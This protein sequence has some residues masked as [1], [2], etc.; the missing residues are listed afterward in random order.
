MK[1]FIE[2]L[3]HN[4]NINYK[5]DLENRIDI[6]YVLERLE[7]I[8]EIKNSDPVDYILGE[9]NELEKIDQYDLLYNLIYNIKE[10]IKKE[11]HQEL[12]KNSKYHNVHLKFLYNEFEKLE[13]I[14]D[15]L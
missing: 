7:D 14:I 11:I 15:I 5:N 13:N 12:E 3:K 4:Q 2:E 1:E 9:A 8:Q 10:N 6:D